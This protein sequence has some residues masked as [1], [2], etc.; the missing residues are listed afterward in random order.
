MR[1]QIHELVQ[2]HA[3]KQH[4]PVVLLPDNY[5]TGYWDKRGLAVAIPE[6]NAPTKQ[7]ADMVL[8]WDPDFGKALPG[9][10]IVCEDIPVARLGERWLVVLITPKNP[11]A[12]AF[13]RKLV[14]QHLPRMA[15][16]YKRQMRD[17]LLASIASCVMDR[18]RELQSS[19]REDSYELERLSLQMMQLSRKLE[20]D[21]QILKLFERPEEYIKARSNRSFCDLLKLVPGVYRELKVDGD[22]VIGTT[23]EVVISYDGCE[24]RFEEYAIEVD[25]RQGKIYIT[26]GTNCNGYIHP[27]V[28]DESSNIC[29]GNIGPLV[30]RLIGQL[31]LFP[32]FQ[33][34][35]QFLTSYNSSDPF[36]LIEKWDPDWVEEEPDDE[37]YCSYCDDYGHTISECES[38]WWC[39]HCNEYVDHDEEDCPN[40]PNE[41]PETEEAHAVAEAGA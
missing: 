29:W 4:V 19:I 41:E 24:Y 17:Q 33:L 28:S 13:I 8:G 37:P 22:S 35:H 26:G 7:I 31:D 21:R 15:R 12:L 10:L 39:E 32:L 25:L 20:G 34:V 30:Q 1:Q 18:K 11:P 6:A 38:S 16:I 9:D 36:Q 5:L 3:Q 23:Y 14:D 2:Y 40:R 27:H